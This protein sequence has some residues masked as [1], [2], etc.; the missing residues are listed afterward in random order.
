MMQRTFIT[1]DSV[2]TE[3]F[4]I[5]LLKLLIRVPDS[6]VPVLFRVN[7]DPHS[8]LEQIFELEF[9][10]SHKGIRL[11]TLVTDDS[12]CLL[13]VYRPKL[14]EARLAD[15]EVRDLLACYGYAARAAARHWQSF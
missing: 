15:L 5:L 1:A 8:I 11:D 9:G 14:L 13:Y 12:G 10:L 7:S 6:N 4:R 2:L 3:N